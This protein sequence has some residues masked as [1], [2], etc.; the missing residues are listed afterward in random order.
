[1][2]INYYYFFLE[3]VLGVCLFYW[4][5]TIEKDT[6]CLLLAAWSSF[7]RFVDKSTLFRIVRFTTAV[8]DRVFTGDLNWD[9]WKEVALF[10]HRTLPASV[11]GIWTKDTFPSDKEL[12]L[13][14]NRLDSCMVQAAGA[15]AGLSTD[16]HDAKIFYWWWRRG[17]IVL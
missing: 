15:R 7:C 6:F 4:N 3:H 5:K 11:Q 16:V 1:M 14:T 17:L 10:S 12:A 8:L 13:P 9:K 2:F